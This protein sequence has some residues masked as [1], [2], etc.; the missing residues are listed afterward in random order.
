MIAADVDAVA[1]ME[2]GILGLRH[3]RPAAVVEFD[4]ETP[5]I[6]GRGPRIAFFH[7]V[8]DDCAAHNTRSRRRR[9]PAAAAELVADHTADNRAENGASARVALAQF[10]LI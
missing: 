6:A 2:A 3:G 4:A 1:G 5:C 8:A 7:V 10:N 9:T